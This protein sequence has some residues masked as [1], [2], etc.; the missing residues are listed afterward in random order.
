MTK[1]EMI[2]NLEECVKYN[3]LYSKWWNK[4]GA[5]KEKINIIENGPVLRTFGDEDFGLSFIGSGIVAFVLTLILIA[6]FKWRF[7]IT[8]FITFVVAFIFILMAAQSGIDKENV[9]LCK[10]HEKLKEALPS[11][12]KEYAEINRKMEQCVEKSSYY[13][14][15]LP[16]D[17]RVTSYAAKCIL[18]YLK[19]GRAD[20]M[21]E[22][23]NL[24]EME[25]DRDHLYQETRRHNQAMEEEAAR[26]SANTA[27]ARDEASRAADASEQAA[28]NAD[29]WG[30][31]NS[32]Q[33]DELKKR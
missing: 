2:R 21:K 25:L 16:P 22:A 20:T 5:V 33:V 32:L 7:F 27:A 15:V 24:Y 28:R 9:I 4:A 19:N 23:I 10:K 12:K 14:Q 6:I 1:Q 31:V 26:Q 18:Q 29:F 8:F 17:Y 13:A 11:L 30:F 3:E